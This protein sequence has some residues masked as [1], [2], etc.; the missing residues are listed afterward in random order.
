M[1][2]SKFPDHLGLV[3]QRDVGG[4]LGAAGKID[5]SWQMGEAPTS[6]QWDRSQR[7]TTID[8]AQ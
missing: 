7:A 5:S 6:F 3:D 2:V 8:T 4:G 1:L